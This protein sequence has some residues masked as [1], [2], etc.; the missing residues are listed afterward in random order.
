M[1]CEYGAGRRIVDLGNS[2]K[3]FVGDFP[4]G[5]GFLVILTTVASCFVGDGRV[6]NV[7]IYLK[8]I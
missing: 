2:P 6:S 3:L 8:N 7:R 1:D 5:A 4:Q